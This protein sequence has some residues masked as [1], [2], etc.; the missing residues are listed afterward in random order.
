MKSRPAK[1]YW[2]VWATTCVAAFLAATCQ[3]SAGGEVTISEDDGRAIVSIDGEPFTE[4]VFR[5]HAKPILYPIIGPYGIEMTRN[6]PMREDVDNEAHDH[7]HQKSVWFTHDD[8]NGAQFWMEYPRRDSDPKPGRIVQTEMLIEGDQIL[9]KND[10]VAP[11]GKIVCSDARVLTFGATPAGRYID[12]QITIRASSGD[13]TFGDTKEG[14]M[15]IRTHPLLRLQSD[16]KRGNHT[17]KG[18]AVNSEGV[19]GKE[20]WGKRAKW[21]DY[22]APIDGKTVGIA[23]FDHPSNPRHP[24]WWHA[25]YYGLVAANPFGIHDFEGKPEGAGDMRIPSGDNVTFRYHF[26]FHRGDVNEADVA[27]EYEMF[28]NTTAK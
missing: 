19:E 2:L 10:W 14:T 6:Y 17:A 21:V 5:R 25:R 26:L 11:D 3:T 28:A 16:E 22:W 12:F 13:V 20:I 27:G 24:T 8:V 23:V 4:Y 15:G 1:L 9:A 7:P 18:S